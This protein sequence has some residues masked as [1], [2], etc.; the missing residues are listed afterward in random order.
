MEIFLHLSSIKI[1]KFSKTYSLELVERSS[2]K[3]HCSNATAFWRT[4]NFSNT[5][6]NVV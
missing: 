2:T 4:A 5:Q 6:I 1:S 3:L